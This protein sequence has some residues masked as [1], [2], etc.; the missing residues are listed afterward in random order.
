MA[1]NYSGQRPILTRTLESCPC[2]EVARQPAQE[3]QSPRSLWPKYLCHNFQKL[4]LKNKWSVA[5]LERAPSDVARKCSLH[6]L[7]LCPTVRQDLLHVSNENNMAANNTNQGDSPRVTHLNVSIGFS[8]FHP[9]VK[10]KSFMLML[11]GH[12]LGHK[13]RR[14]WLHKAIQIHC[15][16]HCSHFSLG[17]LWQL[18]RPRHCRLHLPKEP[19]NSMYCTVK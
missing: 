9:S 16:P 6:S 14:N 7:D 15:R 12:A 3:S 8:S 1:D 19:S 4:H 18:W 5:K 2:H 10:R 17:G 13:G 11:S